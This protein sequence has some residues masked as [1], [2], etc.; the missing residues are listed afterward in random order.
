ML[1]DLYYAPTDR[2]FHHF[3][4]E[5]RSGTVALVEGGHFTGAGS[6]ASVEPA[7]RVGAG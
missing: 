7:V 5:P 2:H 4:E 6:V 1:P 3:N